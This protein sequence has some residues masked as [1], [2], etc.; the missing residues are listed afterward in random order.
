VKPLFGFLSNLIKENYHVARI[1]CLLFFWLHS[2]SPSCSGT[3]FVRGFIMSLSAETKMFFEKVANKN[4]RL[5]CNVYH[6]LLSGHDITPEVR[7]QIH[8]ALRLA[9]QF[10]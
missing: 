9:A 3:W 5:A 6:A 8:E 4:F 1:F 10:D 2:E 7:G